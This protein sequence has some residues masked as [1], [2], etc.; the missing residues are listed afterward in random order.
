M[1]S[2]TQL[3]PANKSTTHSH[4]ADTRHHHCHLSRLHSADED[5]VSWLTNY[6]KRHAYEKKKNELG[7]N[8]FEYALISP[9]EPTSRR[10]RDSNSGLRRP[11]GRLGS[12]H[13]SPVILPTEPPGQAVIQ[14]YAFVIYFQEEDRRRKPNLADIAV[15]RGHKL[16]ANALLDSRTSSTVPV[17]LTP[18][19]QSVSPTTETS[20]SHAVTL[21]RF[22]LPPISHK[23]DISSANINRTMPVSL[24]CVSCA[25]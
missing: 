19:S 7:L 4:G 11:D 20:T 2:T 8:L 10:G 9:H 15:L 12:V 18:A 25:L 21:P 13:P 23:R 6:G 22:L 1:P 3:H 17:S 24:S 5:A 16:S 14:R